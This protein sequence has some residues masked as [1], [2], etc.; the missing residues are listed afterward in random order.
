METSKVTLKA[1]IGLTCIGL[2]I[3]NSVSI[4]S[5]TTANQVAILNDDLEVVNY[6]IRQV[7]A[8][9]YVQSRKVGLIIA[10]QKTLMYNS[11]CYEI[12]SYGETTDGLYLIQPNEDQD[13]FQVE[14]N[15]LNHT[16]WTIIS[17]THRKRLTVYF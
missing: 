6:R 14:C 7:E 12:W 10:E 16:A 1:L 4:Y 15:F 13:P 3:S 11:S 2:L 17:H 9:N 8:E 5:N